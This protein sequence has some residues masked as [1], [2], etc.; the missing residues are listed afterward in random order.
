MY[1]PQYALYDFASC[2]YLDIIHISNEDFNIFDIS[3]ISLGEIRLQTTILTTQPH[4]NRIKG[5]FVLLF[6]TTCLIFHIIS[7]HV[8][9]YVILIFATNKST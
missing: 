2:P 6:F 7:V 9:L 3:M 5:Y 4:Q 1:I 8:L